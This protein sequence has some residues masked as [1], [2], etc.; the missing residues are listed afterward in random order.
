MQLER[1]RL[2]AGAACRL[3]GNVWIPVSLF[4]VIFAFIAGGW[5]ATAGDGLYALVHGA[6]PPIGAKQP[7][8]Y[9]IALLVLVVLITAGA[10][11]ISRA[12]ELANWA[13]VGTIL[14]VLFVIDIIVVPGA[15]LVRGDPW[16]RNAGRP[17]FRDHRQPD[18]RSGGFH[19]TCF[20]TQLVCDGPLPRQG[21]RH[22]LSYRLPCGPAGRKKGAAG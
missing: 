17:A 1:S 8:I 10:R 21:V 3:D 14:V 16:L 7:R 13:M 20:G 22:G 9:A 15:H 2:L 12:L 11:R 6:V 19:G 18:R 5:A 4:I